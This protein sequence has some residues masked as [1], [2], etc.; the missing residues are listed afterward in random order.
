[1]LD[2]IAA[3]GR[4][5]PRTLRI[6][7]D[8]MASLRLLLRDGDFAAV[9]IAPPLFDQFETVGTKVVGCLWTAEGVVREP[10]QTGA[11]TASYWCIHS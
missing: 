9:C 5:P 7:A 11:V 8:A 10:I 3:K 1:M 6:S 4:I 2:A